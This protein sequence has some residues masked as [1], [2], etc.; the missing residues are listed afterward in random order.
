MAGI[1]WKGG[2]LKTASEVR[3][4]LMH[5]DCKQSSREKVKAAK[6]R[7]GEPCHIEPYLCD[8]NQY[9]DCI[10]ADDVYNRYCQAVCETDETAENTRKDRV[11]MLTP[12][13]YLP[14]QV[15]DVIFERAGAPSDKIGEYFSGV[16][17][18]FRE[19]FGSANV[20]GGFVHGD[21]RH[22]YLVQDKTRTRRAG[23]DEPTKKTKELMSLFHMHTAIMAT[24]ETEHGRDF[25]AKAM[26]TRAMMKRINKRVDEYCVKNYGVH[27]MKTA[28]GGTYE[29]NSYTVNEL[30]AESLRLEI[31]E[32]QAKR[33]TLWADNEHTTEALAFYDYCKEKSPITLMLYDT[34]KQRPTHGYNSPQY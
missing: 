21:E 13:V 9:I 16:L 7:N 5:F 12:I 10:D 32:L 25:Q 31:Q 29:Q 6:E 19:E 11:T 23:E 15:E 26:T 24:L 2:K 17:D 3:M 1:Q 8:A 14:E 22:S 27:F 30:K 33:R 20:L 4:K 34:D 28:E 18:I